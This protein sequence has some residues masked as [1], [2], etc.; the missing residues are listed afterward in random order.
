MHSSADAPHIRKRRLV[1]AILLT[2]VV[3]VMAFTAV[4]FLGVGRWLVVKDPLDK[5]QI[6][7]LSGRIPMRAKEGVLIQ[8]RLRTAGL[9]DAR[10]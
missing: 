1:P 5:A 6:V 4:I 10:Q 7:V 9:V 2:V 8:C 3:G